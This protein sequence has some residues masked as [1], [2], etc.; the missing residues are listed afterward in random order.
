MLL[1]CN[2]RPWTVSLKGS[3]PTRQADGFQHQGKFLPLKDSKI[4][5][6][7]KT[8]NLSAQESPYSYMEENSGFWFT[9][10]AAVPTDLATQP[11][12]E[13]EG[14]TYILLLLI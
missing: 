8:D 7:Y 13:E 9:V 5:N 6:Y 1:Q 14:E 12:E 2:R 3:S 4:L 11:T 10:M